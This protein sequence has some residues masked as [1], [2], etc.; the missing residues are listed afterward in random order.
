MEILLNFTG[1]SLFLLCISLLII[2]AAEC[3]AGFKLIRGVVVAAGIA[4][5]LSFGMNFAKIVAEQFLITA[6]VSL[7]MQIIT[8]LIMMFVF[9]F[10]AFKYYTA[11]ALVI[12]SFIAFLIAYTVCG[13]FAPAAVS[14]ILGLIAAAA[15]G[16]ITITAFR[17]YTIICTAALGGLFIGTAIYAFL[18]NRFGF[19]ANAVPGMLAA[20]LGAA[21]QFKATM[22]N[23]ER[24]TQQD[25]G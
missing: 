14:V 18:K 6:S 13:F 15:V 1:L 19:F 2:G 25:N 17:P 22:H 11:G 3:F 5:G 21:F 4:C 10:F 23:S 8:A 20:V 9:S 24:D 16:A 7:I 12:N